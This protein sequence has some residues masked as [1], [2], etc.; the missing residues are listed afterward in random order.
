MKRIFTLLIPLFLSVSVF[1]QNINENPKLNMRL[2]LTSP[3]GNNAGSV[4]WVPSTSKYYTNFAGNIDFPIEVFDEKG[5]SLQVLPCN[6]D[7]RGMWFNPDYGILESNSYEYR[8]IVSYELN[9]ENGY[10]IVKEL[11]LIEIYDLGILN[12][13]AVMTMD[14]SESLYF[15][16][17]FDEENGKISVLLDFFDT[18][19]G[20]FFSSQ[21]LKIPG[22]HLDINYTSS[23][24][25]DIPGAEYGILNFKTKEVYLYG[26]NLKDLQ[27]TPIVKTIKLPKEAPTSEAFNFSYANGHI[28]LYDKNQREWLGYKITR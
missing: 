12:E 2:K 15:H 11:P 4:V 23:I 5:K 18:E 17:D 26:K 27:D 14:I 7:I 28:W 9:P 10:V 19:L 21:Y 22:S 16:V 1:A 6:E 20:D 25:T 24:Y 8:D 13:Q 3:N